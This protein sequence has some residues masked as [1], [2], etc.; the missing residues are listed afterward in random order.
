MESHHY[1]L[2][3]SLGCGFATDDANEITMEV[4]VL[5]PQKPQ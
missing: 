5:A 4:K 2:R 1:E 3:V